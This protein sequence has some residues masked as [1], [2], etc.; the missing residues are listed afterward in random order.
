MNEEDE[1]SDL[2]AIHA[3]IEWIFSGQHGTADQYTQQNHV[4]IVRVIAQ[5]V[6][7][8]TKPAQ[9]AQSSLLAS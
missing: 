3:G 5:L 9:P 1:Q 7:Q 6:A 4:A 2:I 8:H